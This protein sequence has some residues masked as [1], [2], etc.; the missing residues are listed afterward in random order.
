MI[1]RIYYSILKIAAR[2]GTF[3]RRFR[4]VFSED[5]NYNLYK[6]AYN[7]HK[8]GNSDF[9]ISK[10][11]FLTLKSKGLIIDATK[12]G[13]LLGHSHEEGGILVVREYKNHATLVAE[14]EAWEYILSSKAS[15][16]HEESIIKLNE[17]GQYLI[18]SGTFS[19]YRIPEEITTIDVGNKFV[20]GKWERPLLLIRGSKQWCLNKYSSQDYL[21]Q[22]EAMNSES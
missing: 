10:E 12:G 1:I 22:L 19:P 9:K 14:I 6:K 15:I 18:N 7:F 3:P 17:R 5:S 8:N 13:L 11:L 20:D 21:K 2:Y 16:K 4:S